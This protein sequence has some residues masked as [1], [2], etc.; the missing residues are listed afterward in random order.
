M[1]VKVN[2]SQPNGP[3]YIIGLKRIGQAIGVKD[4]VTVK[5]RILRDGLLAIFGHPPGYRRRELVWYTS[6]SLLNQ[7]MIGLSGKS[8]DRL[9]LSVLGQ[10]GGVYRWPGQPRTRRHTREAVAGQDLQSGP[11]QALEVAGYE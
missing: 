3:R 8:R 7:W 1:A 10:R 11:D 9:K 6:E 5:R 4:A 2:Q